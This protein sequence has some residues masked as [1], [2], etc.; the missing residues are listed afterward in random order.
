M[1]DTIPEPLKDRMEMIDVSGYVA[2]EKVSIAQV[3][4]E[5]LS[6]ISHDISP[7]FTGISFFE[8]WPRCGL[9]MLTIFWGVKVC[10]IDNRLGEMLPYDV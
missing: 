9:K 10:R 5:M 2:E 4:N 7:Y 8:S 1:T 6:L 3:R